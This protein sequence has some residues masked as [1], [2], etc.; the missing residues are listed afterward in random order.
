MQP[1]YILY[2]MYILH[3]ILI[4]SH[5]T[6]LHIRELYRETVQRVCSKRKRERKHNISKVSWAITLYIQFFTRVGKW[7]KSDN[8][9]AY[10][11]DCYIILLWQ[12]SRIRRVVLYQIG[13]GADWIWLDNGSTLRLLFLGIKNSFCD[14]NCSLLWFFLITTV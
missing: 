5:N 10:L 1:D 14:M 6:T 11:I 3:A 13:Y 4:K 12:Y 7:W 9:F 8:Y 2:E